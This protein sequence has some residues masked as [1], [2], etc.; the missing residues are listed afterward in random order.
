MGDENV[1]QK[2]K[3]VSLD[4]FRRVLAAAG[5]LLFASLRR[6][7]SAHPARIRRLR[8]LERLPLGPRQALLLVEADGQPLLITL[9]PDS[10]STF[11]ALPPHPSQPA[12]NDLSPDSPAPRPLSTLPAGLP[13]RV[14]SARRAS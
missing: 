1:S 4:T 3:K 11:F 7:P 14:R 5:D 10:A 6:I 8:L 2:M 13:V 12:E 9:S